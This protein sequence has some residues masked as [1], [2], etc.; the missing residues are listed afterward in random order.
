MRMRVRS[1]ASPSGLKIQRCRELRAGGRSGSD[2]ALVGLWWRPEAAAL[3]QALAWELPYAINRKEKKDGVRFCPKVCECVCVCVCVYAR[4]FCWERETSPGGGSCWTWKPASDLF[5]LWSG[6]ALSPPPAR[7]P[8]GPAPSLHPH[9]GPATR[10][11]A[12]VHRPHLLREMA[13]PR[14]GG[15]Q[16]TC[17]TCSEQDWALSLVPSQVVCFSGSPARESAPRGSI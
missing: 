5:L 1:L 4:V 15:I 11:M 3:I 14:Q 17:Q 7:A 16:T 6:C 9:P 10:S 13:F 12:T 8:W 2:L